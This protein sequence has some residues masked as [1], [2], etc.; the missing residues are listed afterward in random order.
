MEIEFFNKD[1]RERFLSPN[2]VDLFIS[3]FP[4]YQR[5]FVE[6]GGD[7]SLQLQNAKDTEEFLDSALKVIK[8]M[9]YALK[10]NGSIVLILPNGPRTFRIIADIVKETKLCPSRSIIW[11]FEEWAQR[12]G[13]EKDASGMGTNIILYLTHSE[14]LPWNIKGLKSFIIKEDFGA[15]LEDQ[16]KYGDIAFIYDALPQTLSD[17]LVLTFSKEGDVVADILAGTGTVAISALKNNR[18]TIYNDSSTEQIKVAKKRIDDIIGYSQNTTT[19]IEKGV[20]MTKEEAVSIMMESINADNLALG[21]QAGIDEEQLKSQIE[22]SQPSLGFMM[23][24]IYDK[25][26]AGGVIA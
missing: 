2:S 5:N 4:F 14:N 25:L 19:T 7:P 10:D 26:Q 11:D 15:S 1:A 8:H 24:N 13:G 18:K 17:L 12:M 23:S 6:Y 3:H 21:L 16:D 22:Q 9:E 20:G